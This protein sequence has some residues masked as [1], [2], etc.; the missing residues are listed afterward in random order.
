VFY[1]TVPFTGGLVL[2]AVFFLDRRRTLHD[3][4]AGLQVLRRLR[5]PELLA[6]GGAA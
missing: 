3:W 6:P 2:L 5:G 4:C 1:V